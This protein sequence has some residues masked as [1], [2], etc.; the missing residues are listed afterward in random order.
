T[1]L[2]YIARITSSFVE[3]HGDRSYSDDPSIIC[4]LAE[5]GGQA[6][7]IIGQQR[8]R[9]G[10]H[11]GP[12][13]FRKAQRA[14]RLAAKFSLPLI[15]L[16]DTPGAYPGPESEERGIGNAI[17]TTMALLSDLPTPVIS[18]IIGQGGSEGALA[19]GIANRI[20]IMENAF[21]SVISPER[22]ASIL[23][24]DVKRAEE[25]AAALKL[26]AADC[27]SLRVV[28]LIIPEPAGGAHIDPVEAARLLKNLII[29]ELLQIQTQ[30]PDKLIKSRYKRL[31]YVGGNA[32]L[33]GGVFSKQTARLQELLKGKVEPEPPVMEAPEEIIE[34][35]DNQT[36]VP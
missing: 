1:S 8:D 7:V 32:P 20:L 23:F 9:N 2:D 3:I 34:P 6:I 22:A 13:G 30:S 33:L 5:M 17:A 36:L 4:G 11:N 24:R 19:L 31:R 25:L 29:R 12:E 28:D 35:D 16:I 26:T 14:M 10:G 15:T 21:L 18:V 27:K